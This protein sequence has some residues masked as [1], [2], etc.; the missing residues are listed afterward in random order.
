MVTR[1]EIW[2]CALDSTVGREIKKTR[3]CLIVSPDEMNRGLSTLIVAPLTSGSR[4]TRFR[5]PVRF[6][7]GDGLIL[8]D[9]MRTIDRARLVKN[10]GRVDAE[11]LRATMEVLNEM[12]AV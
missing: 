11:T 10:V 6:R 5:I 9:Q 8:P 7:D 2:L 1:G 12:F 4:L 3:P